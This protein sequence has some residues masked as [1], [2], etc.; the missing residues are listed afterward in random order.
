MKI[1]WGQCISKKRIHCHLINTSGS[2]WDQWT[3]VICLS[4]FPTSLRKSFCIEPGLSSTQN[5][6]VLT[7]IV[8]TLW[9]QPINSLQTHH[10]SFGL[11]VHKL[12]THIAALKSFIW[13]S[14]R[15][16]FPYGEI[17]FTSTFKRNEKNNRKM[18]SWDNSSF[19]RCH[20]SKGMVI[21]LILKPVNL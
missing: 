19:K 8:L 14:F 12:S 7:N 4:Y 5:T 13:F 16:C 18:Q 10:W 20:M 11:L 3:D 2:Y 17:M 6:S 21:S 15:F 1:F 9:C